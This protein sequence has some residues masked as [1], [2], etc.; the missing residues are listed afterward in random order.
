MA[1]HSILIPPSPPSTRHRYTTLHRLGSLSELL[2]LGTTKMNGTP[3]LPYTRCLSILFG[4]YETHQGLKSVTLYPS[5]PS[6]IPSTCLTHTSSSSSSS[7]R[8]APL[9]L[10]TPATRSSGLRVEAARRPTFYDHIKT[11]L[12]QNLMIPTRRRASKTKEAYTR[13]DEYG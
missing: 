7:T 12:A 3:L 5:F 8:L 9:S 1:L 10:Y 13:R 11:G 2:L 4:T 6:S